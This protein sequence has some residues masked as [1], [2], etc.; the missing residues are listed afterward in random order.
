MGRVG[1]NIKCNFSFYQRKI[2]QDTFV[3]L[4][5]RELIMLL[6]W[7]WISVIFSGCQSFC[8]LL[9]WLVEWMAFC[10]A[11]R[12]WPSVLGICNKTLKTGLLIYFL[13][14]AVNPLPKL[15]AQRKWSPILQQNCN[16]LSLFFP[17]VR[18]SG[19]GGH[20]ELLYP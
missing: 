8:L 17:I 10:N 20:A 19:C 7:G 12:S 5:Y 11:K 18:V 14:I 15:I 6:T 13:R 4:K 3:M 1:N 2:C 9:W 16:V